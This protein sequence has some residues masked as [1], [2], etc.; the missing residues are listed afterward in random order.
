LN[1]EGVFS[2]TAYSFPA[3]V[4]VCEKRARQSVV[5]YGGRI[6]KTADGDVFVIPVQEP[7]PSKLEQCWDPG[8][9][10]ES[11]FTEEEQEKI[12]ALG[13]KK[14][15]QA[16]LEKVAPGWK[17]SN[18]GP[19]MDPGLRAEYRGKKPVFMTHPL[20]REVGC[21]LTRAVE[22][23]ASGKTILKM[24]VA[25]HDRANF[26]LMAKA[27][28]KELLEQTIGADSVNDG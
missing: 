28:G 9:A 24:L 13:P 18:C 14:Q 25:N 6:E 15:Q 22:V 5:K 21:T 1:P 2:H 16:D 26:T 19:D 7:K 23:P 27:D 11:I 10:A 20:N 8:P 12:E 17:L 4:E 3:L